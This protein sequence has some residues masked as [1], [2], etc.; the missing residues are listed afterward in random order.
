[1]TFHRKFILYAGSGWDVSEAWEE[2][3]RLHGIETEVRWLSEGGSK[4]EDDDVRRLLSI[5]LLT[6][7][8]LV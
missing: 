1:V 5:S 8:I 2:F 4:L 6:L 3:D 7:L